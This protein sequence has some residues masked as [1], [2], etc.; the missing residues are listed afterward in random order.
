[1]DLISR[2]RQQRAFAQLVL[3]GD[4]VGVA[5]HQPPLAVLASMSLRA[6]VQGSKAIAAG[7]AG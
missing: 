7:S 1:V 6:D 4:G 3:S 2:R 5:A